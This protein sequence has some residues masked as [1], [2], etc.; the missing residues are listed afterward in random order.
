MAEWMKQPRSR[1][2]R[3]KGVQ[4]KGTVDQGD[5]GGVGGQNVPAEEVAADGQGGEVSIYAE[6]DKALDSSDKAS[7]EIDVNVGDVEDTS[8]PESALLAASGG[9]RGSVSLPCLQEAAPA[10]EL[11]RGGSRRYPSCRC[12]DCHNAV[13]RRCNGDVKNV[14]AQSGVVMLRGGLAVL[15]GRGR[16]PRPPSRNNE[17]CSVFFHGAPQES[18]AQPESWT[19][20]IAL[21]QKRMRRRGRCSE[22]LRSGPGVAWPWV[23]NM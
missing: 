3:A 12:K 1:C 16:R 2:C 9:S 22:L 20:A 8:E 15:E 18:L 11:N 23:L 4:L 21:R 19:D 17:Q 10:V 7:G 5:T 13:K 6:I 14:V